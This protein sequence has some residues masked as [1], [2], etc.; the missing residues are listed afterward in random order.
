MSAYMNHQSLLLSPYSS[1]LPHYYLQKGPAG[2]FTGAGM[3]MTQGLAGQMQ[4]I[5]RGAGAEVVE[6]TL[7]EDEDEEQKQADLAP[8]GHGKHA[9]VKA[10]PEQE[11]HI[12]C[13]TCLQSLALSH[14]D[15][16]GG[17]EP[18]QQDQHVALL[19]LSLHVRFTVVMNSFP[20]QNKKKMDQHLAFQTYHTL[21]TSVH[22]AAMS[23]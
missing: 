3:H 10:E 12:S 9:A 21:P 1:W 5:C 22:T 7:P 16:E 20:N 19:V 23:R 14:G 13:I 11:V 6:L 17:R 4:P 18:G 15:G 8:N 2:P